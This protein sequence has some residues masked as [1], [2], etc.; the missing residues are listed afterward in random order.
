MGRR[1]GA[2]T[3]RRNHGL[4]KKCDC[5]KWSKCGHPW[6]LTF[7]YKRP[8]PYRYSLNKWAEKPVCYAMSKSEA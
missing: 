4:F 8:K 1:L 7:T 3:K 5:A 6:H 2:K